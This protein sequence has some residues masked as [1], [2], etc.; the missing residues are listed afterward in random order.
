[1]F[2][3][4]YETIKKLVMGKITRSQSRK[5]LFFALLWAAVY[6]GCLLVVKELEPAKTWGVL[7]SFLPTITFVLFLFNFIKGIN[8]MDEVERRIQLEA[9]VVAAVNPLPVA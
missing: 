7:V 4:L 5:I 9:T 6:I 8:A 1:M 3:Y 2:T